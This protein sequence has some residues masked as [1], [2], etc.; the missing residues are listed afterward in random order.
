MRR[1][2]AILNDGYTKVAVIQTALGHAPQEHSEVMRID[3]SSP[4]NLV[5]WWYVNMYQVLNF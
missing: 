3:L 2:S 4:L 1:S 5:A